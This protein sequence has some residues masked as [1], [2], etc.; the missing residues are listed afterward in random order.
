M[1]KEKARNGANILI[2]LALLA[3][4]V[5]AFVVMQIRYGGPIFQKYALQDTLIADI[6]PPP[7]YVVE[8][9]LEATLLL[10]NPGEVTQKSAYLAQLHRDYEDRKTYWAGAALSPEQRRAVE[11]C[12]TL[13]DTFW[14]ML[15]QRY[16][17]AIRAGRLDE[18]RRIHDN[19]LAKAYTDQ[20]QAVL[21]LVAMS[22]AYRTA[23]QGKD[24]L[25]VGGAL[26][27]AVLM[28]VMIMAGLW[29]ARRRIE[30]DIVEPL[31]ISA[32]AMHAM[33]Q[34]NYDEV[35]PGLG[36]NDEIGLMA[37]AMKVFQAT[38]RASRQAG[39]HQRDV[40]EALNTGL[41][42]LANKDLEH[43]IY[44]AF[45]PEYDVL[46]L[47]YNRA[48]DALMEAIASVR[49]AA[50][51]LMRSTSEIRVASQDLANR[52]EVQ[53]ASLEE[54][55]ASL[56]EVARA[57]EQSA[58]NTI[59]LRDTA[60]QA[61]QEASMGGK[62]VSRAI[63]TMA[64]IAQSSEEI[65]QIINVIDGIAFQTNLLALNAGVEA[66]RAGEAGKG[67]AV[68]ASEVRALAQRSANAAH[69]IKQLIDNSSSQV[70]SGVQLVNETGERLGGIV[71]QVGR[72]AGLIEE[73]A[74]SS[75]RQA[76]NIG[77]IN[78]AVGEMDIMTQQNAAMV[79]QSHAATSSLSDEA[80]R[81]SEVV[82]TF[83]SRN[84]LVRPG[85]LDNPD[86]MRR[87]TAIE[88]AHVMSIKEIAPL[89]PPVAVLPRPTPR[90]T[91]GGQVALAV[92]GNDWSEF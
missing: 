19:T 32:Q 80:A 25:K 14:R 67:F 18:A 1:I 23:E 74:I 58:A 41:S 82:S 54:T 92:T 3:I 76:L 71:D 86:D 69:D 8:P 73:I 46:R 38:G 27:L 17:P 16:L 87:Q 78:S 4:F 48:L 59:S 29:I 20:H 77:Q 53:A 79:Q 44:D 66:A 89:P 11:Q 31:V 70:A 24:E 35:I 30:R 10:V 21:R 42:K 39:K 72:I 47:D 34:G 37:Q 83:R 64:G 33:A 65:G 15:E 91:G 88:G 12:E 50:A 51:A 63:A 22:N 43:R 26:A 85:Y 7:E 57:V 28:A 68:V 75:E 81:L 56:R 62:V 55:A 60:K 61:H 45:S 40:V 49:V 13:S 36:R 5:S 2:A 9:Y 6:L 52:N 84:R 90:L